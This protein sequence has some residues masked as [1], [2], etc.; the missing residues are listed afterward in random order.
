[1]TWQP[2]LDAASLTEPNTAVP[3][4]VAGTALLITRDENGTVRA[5]EN[6]CPHQAATVC[7]EAQTGEPTVECPNHYWVF[8]LD[9]TFRGSRI[10]LSAGR[11]APS[12]PEKNLREVPCRELDTTIDVDV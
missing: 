6:Q 11:A 8:G 10:A 4:R 1:M 9:G 12:D 2:A 3:V 7:R 5:F